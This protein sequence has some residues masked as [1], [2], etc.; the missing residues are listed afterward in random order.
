MMTAY[1]S[2]IRAWAKNR[3]M[4]DFLT[5]KIDK[6]E[7][8]M[9]KTGHISE[10]YEAFP[11]YDPNCEVEVVMN[12]DRKK[13]LE[14]CTQINDLI[15]GYDGAEGFLGENFCQDLLRM[16]KDRRG[17]KDVDGHIR[18]RPV[19]VKFKW[20]NAENFETRYVTFN[21][22]AKFDL[23]IV[24]CADYGDSEVCLFGIWKKEEVVP[25][26]G[27]Q[28]RVYLKKL[29]KQDQAIKFIPKNLNSKTDEELIIYCAD[30]ESVEKN[31][32]VKKRLGLD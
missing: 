28:N 25:I 17:I 32:L 16:T 11:D 3:G 21:P 13:V 1:E 23:L 30:I 20:L 8:Y 27:A 4:K 15:E 18:G 14:N 10:F 9:H 6:V 29:L 31:K 2:R 7:E 26:I 5:A 19:Q 24:T 22:D 12:T